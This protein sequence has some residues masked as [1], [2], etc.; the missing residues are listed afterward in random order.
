[1]AVT[2]LPGKVVQG[3]SRLLTHERCEISGL[4]GSSSHIGALSISMKPLMI[5]MN[6]SDFYCSL[7][8]L[9]IYE[10][11]RP[12]PQEKNSTEGHFHKK[13]HI[14]SEDVQNS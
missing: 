14:I 8:P 6:V 5:G 3:A 4:I 13:L 9:R 2:S 11:S 10:S 12:F 7:T 1:M